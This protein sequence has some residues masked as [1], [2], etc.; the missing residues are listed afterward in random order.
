[1]SKWDGKLNRWTTLTRWSRMLSTRWKLRFSLDIFELYV[2]YVRMTAY[3]VAWGKRAIGSAVLPSKK[4]TQICNWFRRR[5]SDVTNCIFRK[6]FC[7]KVRTVPANQK[8][9]HV[10]IICM[11]SFREQNNTLYKEL[12]KKCIIVLSLFERQTT[13]ICHFIKE[14][15][16]TKQKDQLFLFA[17][18][19]KANHH[20]TT[21]FWYW[22]IKQLTQRNGNVANNN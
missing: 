20:R 7:N 21:Y 10:N 18:I 2:P 12:T 11:R 17:L 13:K 15:Q 8:R 22:C 9:S 16:K 6:H 5:S 14:N 4:T 3:F 1:M 19:L